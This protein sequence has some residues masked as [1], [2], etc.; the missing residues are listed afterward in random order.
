[1]DTLELVL[2]SENIGENT[3]RNIVD[4]YYPHLLSKEVRDKIKK[5]KF[6]ILVFNK[7][8]SLSIFKDK[9]YEIK[10]NTAHPLFYTKEIPNFYIYDKKNHKILMGLN[11]LD[12][13]SDE[14]QLNQGYKYIMNEELHKSKNVKII[15]VVCN[16]V[17]VQTKNKTFNLFNVGIKK[18]RMCYINGLSS[19]IKDF[20]NIGK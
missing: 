4:K 13:W 6:N 10:M 7:I 5:D 14:T 8:T 17:N 11:H 12:L 18:D 16:F 9:N 19:I 2:N 20:L 1:M 15:H 3:I